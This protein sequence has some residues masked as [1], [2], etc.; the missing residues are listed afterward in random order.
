[1][2]RTV[3]FPSW[4]RAAPKGSSVSITLAHLDQP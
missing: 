1:M 2:Q 4:M 3:E